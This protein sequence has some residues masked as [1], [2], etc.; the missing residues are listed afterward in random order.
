MYEM[1]NNNLVYLPPISKCVP[2]GRDCGKNGAGND[3][4]LPS[5]SLSFEDLKKIGRGDNHLNFGVTWDF[6]DF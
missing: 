1:E 6:G 3:E 5:G 4:V 2:K